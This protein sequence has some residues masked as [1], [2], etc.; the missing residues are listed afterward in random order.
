[1]IYGV[2]SLSRGQGSPY[3]TSWEQ[4]GKEKFGCRYLSIQ[5]WSDQPLGALAQ[6][7]GFAEAGLISDGFIL[8]SYQTSYLVSGWKYLS[9]TIYSFGGR[10]TLLLKKV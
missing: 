1:M 4:K 6:T 2:H 5:S 9:F 3:L 10:D 8:P 7:V